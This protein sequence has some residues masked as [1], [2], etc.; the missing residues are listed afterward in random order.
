MYFY[1]DNNP[2]GSSRPSYGSA[3]INY[4]FKNEGTY[5]Y[6]AEYCYNGYSYFSNTAK[7]IVTKNNKYPASL[8]MNSPTILQGTQLKYPILV[9]NT[10][11]KAINEGK[12]TF[13]IDNKYKTQQNVYNGKVNINIGTLPAG[14]HVLEAIFISNNYKT[15]ILTK[16]LTVKSNQVNI[17]INTTNT[18]KT[19]ENLIIKTRIKSLDGEPVGNNGYITLYL[20]NK[21]IKKEK[22]TYAQATFNLGKQ[23]EGTYTIKATYE[24]PQFVTKTQTKTITVYDVPEKVKL[25]T[26]SKTSSNTYIKVVARVT[27]DGKRVNGGKLKITAKWKTIYENPNIQQ[28]LGAVYYKTPS[29][30][31]TYTI[32]AQ[33]LKNGK[34]ITQDKKTITIP[35]PQI[36]L[37]MPTESET[38]TNIK[39]I[40][41]IS[42]DG[43]TVNTGQIKIIANGKTIYNKNNNQGLGA[44][45]YKT[46]GKAG[47]YTITT[48][49]INNGKTISQD[50]QT[51]KII[52]TENI[53][54]EISGSY[55]P[56]KKITLTAYVSKPSGTVNNGN[57]RFRVD[58]T[59]IGTKTVNNGMAVMT[60]TLPNYE[61]YLT[62]TAEYIKNGEKIGSSSKNINVERKV[63]YYSSYARSQ[64]PYIENPYYDGAQMICSTINING[65]YYHRGCGGLLLDNGYTESAYDSRKLTKS[66]ICYECGHVFS[67]YKYDYTEFL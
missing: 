38:D 32:V 48:Q 1:I 24:R 12:I 8:S 62:C 45:Y 5:E 9:R 63:I 28:G 18:I 16:T 26:P 15:T 47:T 35:S 61:T 59:T 54:L 43:K 56:N 65:D 51:L 58:G 49:Y 25:D 50:T 13:Y 60:Y 40:A 29:T 22:V 53:N 33:Y 4:N 52:N 31:G 10:T 7:I 2:I 67:D 46:P 41:R 42:Q 6:N 37:S 39:I 21:Y 14:T 57:V 34:L 17:D 44:V 20:N 55:S 27:K 36:K 23:K 19:T 66:L 11:N 3:S 64:Q 30:P